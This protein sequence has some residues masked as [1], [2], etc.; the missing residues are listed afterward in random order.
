MTLENEH[1]FQYLMVENPKFH[2]AKLAFW[3]L[4]TIEIF[5]ILLLLF[6]LILGLDTDKTVY[7]LLFFCFHIFLWVTTFAF[8]LGHFSTRVVVFSC[9]LRTITFLFGLIGFIWHTTWQSS[10]LARREDCFE[11]FWKEWIITTCLMV[12]MSCNITNVILLLIVPRLYV[13]QKAQTRLSI[14]NSYQDAYKQEITDKVLH[15]IQRD[16]VV[17]S[18]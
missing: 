12:F 1:F 14:Q 11:Q 13:E 2:G 7:P 10:C 18:K 3:F 4:F 8:S 5:A 17:A 9:S 6:V 15:E 16:R